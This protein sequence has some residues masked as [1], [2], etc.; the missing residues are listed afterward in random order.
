M[1]KILKEYVGETLKSPFISYYD[2][3]N[4]Y[5]IQVI[6]LRHQVDY[7]IPK[8]QWF[9]EFLTDPA[10]V[11]ARLFVILVRHRQIEMIAEGNKTKEVKNI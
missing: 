3:K 9:E 7:I 6:A 10:N 2:M 1:K 4:I 11:I 8:K 5:P